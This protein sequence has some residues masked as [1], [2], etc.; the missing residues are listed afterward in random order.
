MTATVDYSWS[1]VGAEMIADDGFVGA[2]RY[3]G[4]D[5][6]C[7][8]PWERDE[9]LAAGVGIGLIWELA[10]D[11]TLDGYNAGYSDAQSA[12]G[13]AD[14]LGAPFEVPI[15]Y[16][17]DFHASQSQI[18][19]P[20]LE[21]HRGVLDAGGRPP[22]IYGG[23]PVIDMGYHRLGIR[24]GWQAAA[25]SW[26]NYELSPNAVLLQEV[27]QIYG[28][29]CDVNTVLCPADA[30][31]WLWGRTPVRKDWFD[32]ATEAD[33]EAVINRVL[34]QRA[35]ANLLWQDEHGQYELVVRGDGTR[36]RRR[37]ASPAEADLL[38]VGDTI[39]NSKHVDVSKSP[40]ATRNVW[41]SWPIIDQ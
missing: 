31:D 6:R 37:I 14:R 8:Q 5:G 9:L 26:S 41:Y 19:G 1:Y 30:I 36:A 16:A 2:E 18:D 38:R 28:G 23:A 10:A 40:E 22:G 33:L 4:D 12:N 32:M 25:A 15:R 39:A 24:Y 17:T 27:A 29:A 3:L 34:D 7:I 13:Y 11:R 20:I 35:S 21:Y